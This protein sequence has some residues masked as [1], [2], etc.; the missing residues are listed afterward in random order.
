MVNLD[1]YDFNLSLYENYK[2]AEY[3]DQVNSIKEIKSVLDAYKEVTTSDTLIGSGDYTNDF[4]MVDGRDYYRNMCGNLEENVQLPIPVNSGRIDGNNLFETYDVSD[5]VGFI[6]VDSNVPATKESG[7]NLMKYTSLYNPVDQTLNQDIIHNKT[8]PSIN[9]LET[10]RAY[11]GVVDGYESYRVVKDIYNTSFSDKYTIEESISVVENVISALDAKPN[12]YIQVDAEDRYPSYQTTKDGYPFDKFKHR[13]IKIVNIATEDYVSI[14]HAGTPIAGGK[15]KPIELPYKLSENTKVGLSNITDYISLNKNETDLSDD[16]APSIIAGFSN[17]T[18]Q[19]LIK[20]VTSYIH[21]ANFFYVDLP[22]DGVP[23]GGY[24]M[25]SN[26]YLSSSTLITILQDY[27]TELN[28]AKIELDILTG[29]EIKNPVGKILSRNGMY[30]SIETMGNFDKLTSLYLSFRLDTIKTTR[31]LNGGT[32]VPQPSFM[33]EMMRDNLRWYDN[34]Y[35]C[36]RKVIRTTVNPDYTKT[37]EESTDGEPFFYEDR[38]IVVSY[39]PKRKMPTKGLVAN[40]KITVPLAFIAASVKIDKPKKNW[41]NV[42]LTIVVIVILTVTPG[43]QGI[44]LALAYTQLYFQVMYL[45]T[46]KAFYA[47]AS[48][49]VGYLQLA[50]GLSSGPQA[51]SGSEA[52]GIL[53]YSVRIGTQVNSIYHENRMGSADDS[54]QSMRREVEGLELQ[55]SDM[56][57]K[58]YD[59]IDYIFTEC[60]TMNYGGY[61]DLT[62]NQYD[63]AYI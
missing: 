31:I 35:V 55:I 32:Q 11:R 40:Q 59:K 37:D 22:Y 5:L 53:D 16:N 19:D 56:Q 26:E 24:T 21:G 54:I 1:I 51:I 25:R 34:F 52:L 46:G 15:F 61:V 23:T 33:K 9:I 63:N 50:Y 36:F 62:Y 44:A 4:Y 39:L 6:D 17:E 42:I 27:L 3:V 43:T 30:P 28:K 58:L 13:L 45:A 49:M 10:A 47:K 18:I 2:R 8:Y 41:V 38:Y 14:K 12:V 7:Y 60:H 20:V 48:K 57:E 29:E